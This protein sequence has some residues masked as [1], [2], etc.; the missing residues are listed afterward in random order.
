MA[1]RAKTDYIAIHCSASKVTSDIGAA[2]IRDWHVNDNG[3]S[4]IGYGL[5]IRRS[6]LLEMGRG[7][8][9]VGAHVKGFN[10]ISVG[11]CMVGGLDIHGRP[12]DNFTPEQYHTLE[13]TIKFLKKLYP[14][15][16]VQGH[17]D[18]PDVRKDCPCF[19][20]KSWCRGR[21]I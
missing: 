17:R 4:D 19:D 8:D 18:F 16:K 13:T 20:V 9:E 15:A 6:G 2:E 7:I 12:E 5:V 14:D 3:W 1:K 10:S 11:V 21:G